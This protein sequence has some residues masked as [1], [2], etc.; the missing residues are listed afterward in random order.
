MDIEPADRVSEAL[1]TVLFVHSSD[2]LYGSDRVLLDLVTHLDPTRIEPIVVLPS[3]VPGGGALT[4]RLTDA[5]ITTI[6]RPLAVMRRRDL[7]PRGAIVLAWRSAW[8]VLALRKLARSRNVDLVYSNTTAVQSGALAARTLGLPHVWHVHEIV[9]QPRVLARLLRRNLAYYST[10]IVAVSAAVERW[11]ATSRV[12]V[13]VV[14]NGIGEPQ[15][16]PAE[17]I[18]IRARYLGDSTGRLIGWVGRLGAWKGQEVFVDMA[19]RCAGRWPDDVF[20]V[21]GAPVPGLE[22]LE[23]QLRD[24]LARGAAAGR[25]QYAGYVHNGPELVAALDVLVACPTRPDPFPRV[26]EEALWHGVPVLGV[27]TGGIPELVD[28]GATGILVDEARPDALATGLE[29]LMRPGQLERM[30]HNARDQAARRFNLEKFVSSI[31]ELLA[32]L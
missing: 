25:I 20:I 17:R 10:A 5:G 2:E 31:E 24:R 27:R 23:T 7:S 4:A 26:V 8:D 15:L 12:P 13:H 29:A 3:D 22:H 21:A 9:E 28:D 11:I 19:E 1:R 14:P 6:R 30:G 16:E 18:R 32:S